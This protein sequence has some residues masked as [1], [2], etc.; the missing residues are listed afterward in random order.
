MSVSH[1]STAARIVSSSR[2]ASRMIMTSYGRNASGISP[3]LLRAAVRTAGPHGL[4]PNPAGGAEMLVV[5]REKLSDH[6]DRPIAD[7]PTHSVRQL[8][9][10]ALNTVPVGSG[11]CRRR[12]L[13]AR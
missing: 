1:R 5:N 12:A 7:D 8:L 4:G 11:G 3:S 6:L 10:L 13:R 9:L 2:S